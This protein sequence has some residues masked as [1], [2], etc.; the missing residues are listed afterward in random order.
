MSAE[1]YE[2]TGNVEK[3][4]GAKQSIQI[5]PE[6]ICDDVNTI[7]TNDLF[8]CC[9]CT[10]KVDSKIEMT[11]C[12]YIT[13]NSIGLTVTNTISFAFGS[14]IENICCCITCAGKKGL[15]IK[16]LVLSLILVLATSGI[17]GNVK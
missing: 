6:V 11:K 15:I 4:A 1:I 3:V 5:G 10:K 16:I 14:F 7:H 12:K 17:V 9:K 13:Q 2:K 8:T